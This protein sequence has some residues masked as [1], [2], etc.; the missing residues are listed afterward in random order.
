MAMSTLR[1]LQ[2]LR[3]A[4]GKPVL[5]TSGYRSSEHTVE[6]KKS[7]PG[8]HTYGRAVDVGCSGEQAYEL[9]AAA[10]ATGWT[11]VGIAQRGAARFV[12]LDDVVKDEHIFY[13][14][15]VWSY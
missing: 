1:R 9:L 12:H 15:A 7:Q 13:R 11:G 3:Y 2:A 4:L 14:P 6:K 8:T 5:I 10:L